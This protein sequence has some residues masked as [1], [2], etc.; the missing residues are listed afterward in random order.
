MISRQSP[1]ATDYRSCMQWEGRYTPVAASFLHIALWQSIC[2][3]AEVIIGRTVFLFSPVLSS[4]PGWACIL[5][6]MDR[7]GIMA[8]RAAG[9]HVW[10]EKNTW[11]DAQTATSPAYVV[12]RAT[13]R[14]LGSSFS[15]RV[16][17]TIINK[18]VKY[19][20]FDPNFSVLSLKEG[21]PQLFSP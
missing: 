18:C 21:W 2:H 8:G 12:D 5:P 15:D 6:C 1:Y 3:E 4:H 13:G 17:E 11:R 14:Q 20:A 19:I 7:R 16:V 10:G 9:D